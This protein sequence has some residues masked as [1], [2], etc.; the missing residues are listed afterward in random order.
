MPKSTKKQ[1]PPVV[2]NHKVSARF[3]KMLD[4]AAANPKKGLASAPIDLTAFKEL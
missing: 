4:K 2:E 1:R 3:L